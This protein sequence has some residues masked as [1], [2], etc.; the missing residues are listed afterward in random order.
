MGTYVEGLARPEGACAATPAARARALRQRKV[1]IDR[2]LGTEPRLTGP[3]VSLQKRPAPQKQ[4][5]RAFFC[6]I[7][8]GRR[9]KK[10]G[11]QQHKNNARQPQHRRH[12]AGKSIHR[13]AHTVQGVS[14]ETAASPAA[15]HNALV[16]K[17][18]TV[19]RW[20][21]PHAGTMTR[22]QTPTA[23]P[24]GGIPLHLPLSSRN[25]A[26]QRHSSAAC[27]KISCSITNR[28]WAV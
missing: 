7:I 24:N 5:V 22:Q 23:G 9:Y 12:T 3:V 4:G 16:S 25:S 15:P 26:R 19:C 20:R 8:N 18:R 17:A 27:S 2:R 13:Q 14:R 28:S 6:K 11:K 10:Q 21:A 1:K